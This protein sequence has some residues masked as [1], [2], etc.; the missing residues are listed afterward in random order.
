MQK[1][2]AFWRAA[3]GW[4]CRLLAIQD[5]RLQGTVRHPGRKRGCLGSDNWPS[6]AGLQTPII[7]CWKPPAGCPQ[8]PT[9]ATPI[10]LHYKTRMPLMKTMMKIP[11]VLDPQKEGGWTITSPLVPELVTEIDELDDRD[12]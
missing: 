5:W 7:D 6:Q 11:L 12:R 1:S 4:P 10:I 3:E 8:P 9:D 2:P